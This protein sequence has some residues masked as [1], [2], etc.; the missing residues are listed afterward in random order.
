[1]AP[2]PMATPMAETVEI[3]ALVVLAGAVVL[4][5]LLALVKTEVPHYPAAAAVVVVLTAVVQPLGQ[6]QHLQK[7]VTAVLEL[8]GLVVVLAQAR[9]T[10]PVMLDQMAAAAA[11]EKELETAALA[12]K[13]LLGMQPMDAA[14]AVVAVELA[15]VVAQ[16]AGMAQVAVALTAQDHRA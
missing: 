4:L 11:A 12:E 7:Q 6:L 2:G 10:Q 16:V 8:A 5:A 14:A 3:Q 15:E 1:M 13:I 9:P